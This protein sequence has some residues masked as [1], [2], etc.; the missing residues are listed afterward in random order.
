MGKELF[1]QIK[2]TPDNQLFNAITFNK[3]C[4]EACVGEDLPSLRLLLKK[5]VG[6]VKA[7]K[8]QNERFDL[9]INEQRMA[10]EKALPLVAVMMK[11]AMEILAKETPEDL[12]PF[13]AIVNIAHYFI[14]NGSFNKGRDIKAANELKPQLEELKKSYDS[15]YQKRVERASQIDITVNKYVQEM[16]DGEECTQ[17]EKGLIDFFKQEISSRL[18]KLDNSLESQMT[19]KAY[20]Q[21]IMGAFTRLLGRL[22]REDF[23]SIISEQQNIGYDFAVCCLNFYEKHPELHPSPAEGKDFLWRV[24]N[25]KRLTDPQN[26]P[27]EK[28]LLKKMGSINNIL[29]PDTEEQKQRSQAT[30]DQDVREELSA[31]L[32]SIAHEH[33]A[34]S[35]GSYVAGQTLAICLSKATG[36]GEI[37]EK[38]PEVMLQI[39]EY[40][41]IAQE[42]FYAFPENKKWV[43]DNLTGVKQIFDK[44]FRGERAFSD[45]L[46]FL[47]LSL[48]G[49][50]EK[51]SKD[52][53]DMLIGV[54]GYLANPVKL[55]DGVDATKAEMTLLYKGLRYGCQNLG[56]H[57][58]EYSE[59]SNLV[60]NALSVSA[61]TNEEF[62]SHWESLQMYFPGAYLNFLGRFNQQADHTYLNSLMSLTQ[63]VPLWSTLG[64][65]RGLSHFSAPR[66]LSFSGATM[67][68]PR[69]KTVE[70]PSEVLPVEKEK[71]S[72]SSSSNEGE[73]IKENDV[74]SPREELPSVTETQK[75]QE[76]PLLE[77]EEKGDNSEMQR[78]FLEMK[79]ELMRVKQECADERER[80]NVAEKKVVHLE[81]V[82]EELAHVRQ[83]R[84]QEKNHASANE[85]QIEKLQSALDKAV[86]EKEEILERARN[87]KANAKTLQKTINGVN[88]AFLQ[89]THKAEQ[90][91]KKLTETQAQL[92]SKK[93]KFGELN[94]KFKQSK[95]KNKETNA[96]VEQLEKECIEL[97]KQF[98]Q[99]NTEHNRLKEDRSTLFKK[100]LDHRKIL[101]QSEN[102]KAENQ[103]LA[104]ENVYANLK[105]QLM[106]FPSLHS[107]KSEEKNATAALT[108]IMELIKELK[109]H[110]AQTQGEGLQKERLKEMMDLNKLLRPAAKG[111]EHKEERKAIDRQL[112]SLQTV[113][114]G[115]GKNEKPSN[116]QTGYNAQWFKSV[117]IVLS[118]S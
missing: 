43:R 11:V 100:T 118:K 17:A 39:R 62:K 112:H 69:T 22:A 35:I 37:H 76:E 78:Q 28:A 54:A 41:H 12:V 63:R 71:E 36:I 105:I 32:R 61:F 27:E 5:C 15:A 64:S 29:W 45:K 59:S 46:N 30:K 3:F 4:E 7:T 84:D 14:N 113:L 10:P 52:F 88:A 85:K 55:G 72:A 93:E 51:Y 92:Q 44:H 86:K 49:A 38:S 109:G 57:L 67:V 53:N 47:W 74:S 111:E 79:K 26:S 83:E 68:L 106:I 23:K 2:A 24:G 33:S 99:L 89:E 102:L 82:Q 18:L 16:S 21:K 56:I 50:V 103:K 6:K 42:A 107:K 70:N 87:H 81:Q 9:R 114:P 19:K 8:L 108:K 48:D 80:A 97:Q 95:K 104:Y 40:L 94:C 65:N 20:Q 90:L 58:G 13:Q 116:I 110:L 101:E 115:A 96:K 34:S 25:Y 98:H 117:G 75:K 73:K 31:L 1:K 66:P 91:E 77:K 60:A